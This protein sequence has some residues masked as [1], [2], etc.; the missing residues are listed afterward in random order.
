[1]F[2][3]MRS[4]GHRFAYTD[5][6][7]GNF[8]VRKN[9]FQQV[10]GFKKELVRHHDYELGYRFLAAGAE[11]IYNEAAATIHHERSSLRRTLQ[12]KVAEGVDDVILGRLYPGLIPVLPMYVL[13]KYLRLP[14]Q[15]MML[16]GFYW[17]A[18]GDFLAG[19]LESTLGPFERLRQYTTWLRILSA[20][21]IYWYWR[22]IA[23][24]LKSFR[25]LNELLA[26]AGEGQGMLPE[27]AIH[28][29]EGLEAAADSLEKARPAA[30]ALYW[31]DKMIGR[32]PALPGT[33]R[34]QGRH[35]RPLLAHQF[36]APF[37]HALANEHAPG[38][39]VLDERLREF[40]V[41]GLQ[42]W[43]EPIWRV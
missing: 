5:L 16:F 12:G 21:M 41:G 39:P 1:M 25:K 26:S 3:R 31:K 6:M 14:S 37:F 36:R 40:A 42:Y 28:L 7:S 4:D 15:I 11:F 18:L 27:L 32:I 2:R 30:A 29:E 33:E 23:K 10:G 24:E 13:R 17:P 19:V 38:V 8:S 20:L 9:L 34:L 35:L 22:G 43:K